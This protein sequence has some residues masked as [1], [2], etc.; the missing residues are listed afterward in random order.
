MPAPTDGHNHD[1]VEGFLFVLT[2]LVGVLFIFLTIVGAGHHMRIKRLEALVCR[3]DATALPNCP[4][5]DL[6]AQY[7][8]LKKQLDALKKP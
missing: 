7:D 5:T 2:L 6:Q 1:R 3:A 8:A 4:K